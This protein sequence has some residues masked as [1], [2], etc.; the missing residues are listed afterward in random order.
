MYSFVLNYNKNKYLKIIISI[1][2]VLVILFT[3]SFS[4]ALKP[5]AFAISATV[6]FYII[7]TVAASIAISIATTPEAQR[8]ISHWFYYEASPAVVNAVNAIADGISYGVPMYFQTSTRGWQVIADSVYNLFVKTPDDPRIEYTTLTTTT[9]NLRVD[10]KNNFAINV[11]AINAYNYQIIQCSLG[12]STLT[13]HNRLSYE[14]LYQMVPVRLGDVSGDNNLNTPANSWDPYLGVTVVEPYNINL[15][16][17]YISS[18]YFNRSTG[19]VVPIYNQAATIYNGYINTH[20]V[21]QNGNF[22]LNNNAD[23]YAY[24]QSWSSNHYYA[25]IGMDIFKDDDGYLYRPGQTSDGQYAFI[26]Y[27]NSAEIWDNRKFPSLYDLYFWYYQQI[28]LGLDNTSGVYVPGDTSDDMPGVTVNDPARTKQLLDG[29][30]ARDA[31]S[32]LTAVYP[33]TDTKLEELQ[34][35][36]E[37]V[38]VDSGDAEAYPAVYEGVYQG[39]I[40]LPSVDGHLWSTKF[41]FCIPFDIINMINGFQSSAEAPKF[42]FLVIPKGSF[43]LDIDDQY[44]TIDFSDQN[45]NIFIKIL[46]FFLSAAFVIWLIVL[47]R[48]VIGAE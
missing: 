30:N 9:D 35:N 46:R 10:V 36:P 29:I 2:L 23:W 15:N 40:E 34:A 1:C 18:T 41:P 47:T 26:G 42:D 21:G 31:D 39:D 33:G 11:P 14:D 43:G 16:H 28:G 24:V 48:K 25:N 13:F 7:A 8:E 45:L 12:S 19:S 4:T 6:V 5:K 32:D 27:S 37:A 44:I 3:V 38:I 17:Y 22:Y 20:F